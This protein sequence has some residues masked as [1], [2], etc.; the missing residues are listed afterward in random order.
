MVKDSR[1]W[2]L[3]C[4]VGLSAAEVGAM[5]LGS[6]AEAEVGSVKARTSQQGRAGHAQKS[7]W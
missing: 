2:N 3:T 5:L 4:L 7:C 6:F 1:K